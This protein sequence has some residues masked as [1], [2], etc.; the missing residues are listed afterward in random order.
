MKFV[1][2]SG[3]VGTWPY[4]VETVICCTGPLSE[5]KGIIPQWL[6]VLLVV[7]PF[8]ELLLSEESQLI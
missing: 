4:V 7:T 8:W 1:N 5:W 2:R 6:Q 3:N